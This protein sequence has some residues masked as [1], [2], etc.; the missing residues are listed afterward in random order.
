MKN[1]FIPNIKNNPAKN[2]LKPNSQIT[3]MKLG[4]STLVQLTQKQVFAPTWEVRVKSPDG[5]EEFFINA[6]EGKVIEFK[7]FKDFEDDE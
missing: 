1:C 4:Y 7:D 5:T 3:S 2:L 6:F